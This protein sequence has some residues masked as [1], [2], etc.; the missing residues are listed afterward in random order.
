MDDFYKAFKAQ[1]QVCKDVG[2]QWY[3]NSILCQIANENMP[4]NEDHT[5]A[6]EA[7][8]TI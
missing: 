3:D 1:V 4:N 8:T 2:L 5:A 7:A 6:L